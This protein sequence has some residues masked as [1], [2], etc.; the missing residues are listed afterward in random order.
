MP[1]RGARPL[2]LAARS[3]YDSCSATIAKSTRWRDEVSASNEA[4]TGREIRELIAQF[5]WL[6]FVVAPHKA[7]H[8]RQHVN[9]FA[10]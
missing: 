2:S 8:S 6:P 7:R 10:P 5:V 3:A 1:G 4:G 9:P